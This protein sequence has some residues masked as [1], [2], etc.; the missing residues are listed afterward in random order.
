[1]GSYVPGPRPQIV[2]R[3]TAE[4]RRALERTARRATAAQRDVVRARIVLLAADGRSNAQIARA[5]GCATNTVRMWRR[6]FARRRLDGLADLP[7]P[8]RPPTY[9]ARARALVTA[10]ACSRP[11]DL[12]LPLARLSIPEIR[13]EATKVL[14]PCP[15]ETTIGT[16]LREDAIRPWRYEMWVAPRDPDFLKK[17][18]PA[19]DLYAGTWKGKPL[20]PSDRVLCGDEKPIQAL[21]RVV[22]TRPPGPGRP[23]RYE[24]E[25]VREG[26]LVHQGFLDVRSGKVIGQR[27]PRNTAAAFH[28][29]VGK[30]MRRKRYRSARR[31]FFI[32][33]NGSAHLPGPFAAWLR[34]HHPTVV[35]V[36]LPV[37]GSWVNQMEIYNG[38][39]GKKVLT[40]RDFAS[41]E[42]L[43]ARLVAFERRYNGTARPFDW[44]FARKDLRKLLDRL[45]ASDSKGHT[46]SR[47][48]WPRSRSTSARGLSVAS[49]RT[50]RNTTER[51]AGGSRSGSAGRTRTWTPT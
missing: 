16:W 6:R 38:I 22:P 7:R 26:V 39:L 37:H 35:P 9:D 25:Y 12:G 41:P 43:D 13:R 20:G 45:D 19:L 46:G 31:V 50:R 34:A 30:V 18:G 3:L 11:A 4:E 44:R 2:L 28:G 48:R 24:H 1:M 15:S 29:L 21:R 17:A 32:V 36:P 47:L 51:C 14:R 33:D 42:E 40:P 49:R 27:V 8:G 23:G 5:L 10:I